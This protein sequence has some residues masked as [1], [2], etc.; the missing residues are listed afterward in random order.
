M[1]ATVVRH[2]TGYRYKQGCRCDDCKAAAS[3]SRNRARTARRAAAR[4]ERTKNQATTLTFTHSCSN[5]GSACEYVNGSQPREDLNQRSTALVK[6]TKNGC[7][8]EWLLIV[9]VQPAH[10]EN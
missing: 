8:K 1:T 3:V 5:C 4:V 10:Q 6:C 7:R 2:G 9:V